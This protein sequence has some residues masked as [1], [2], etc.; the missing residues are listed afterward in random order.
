[1]L[2]QVV[3]QHML[4]GPGCAASSALYLLQGPLSLH[5]QENGEISAHCKRM[6][7]SRHLAELAVGTA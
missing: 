2:C 6:L 5:H 1:M 4:G 3:L 7:G